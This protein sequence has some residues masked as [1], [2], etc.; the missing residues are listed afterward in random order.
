VSATAQ[1]RARAG[2]RTLVLK[3]HG[4]PPKADLRRLVAN[5]SMPDVGVARWGDRP[6]PT[7]VTVGAKSYFELRELYARS[8]FVAVPLL[9]SDS[10]NGITQSSRRLQ[11]ERR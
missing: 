9:P 2:F 10:D 8:R 11:W 6:L 5:G 7:G 4:A 1:I 3:E